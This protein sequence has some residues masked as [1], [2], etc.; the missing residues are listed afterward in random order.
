MTDDYQENA[1]FVYECL[2]K[3]QKKES[4]ISV[5]LFSCIK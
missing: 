3:G 5:T 4:Y 1:T 2:M